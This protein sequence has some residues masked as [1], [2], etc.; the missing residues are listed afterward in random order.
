M[1]KSVD[2]IDSP[3]DNSDSGNDKSNSGHD[4]AVD[5]SGI[6]DTE[7]SFASGSRRKPN[8]RGGENEARGGGNET[9]TRSTNTSKSRP[10]TKGKVGLD[11]NAAARAT[12]AK[13]VCGLH[14]LASIAFNQPGFCDITEGQSVE[15]TN[16]VIDVMQHYDIGVS[17]KAAAWGN[18]LA[19]M[20]AIYTPKILY[21]IAQ[22]KQRDAENVTESNVY[23]FATQ[24]R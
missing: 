17:P 4:R 9:G 2:R 15:L 16:A 20:T 21:V 14:K 6:V 7:K 18:L 22:R 11:L 8:A 19:V 10:K 24:T 5:E 1:D 23:G 3:A 12:L 13:Q